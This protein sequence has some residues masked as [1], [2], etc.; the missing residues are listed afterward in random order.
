MGTELPEKPKNVQEEINERHGK[1][2]CPY[3]S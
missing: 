1:L 3:Q 2:F